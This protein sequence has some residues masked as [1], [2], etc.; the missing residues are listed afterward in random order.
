MISIPNIMKCFHESPIT[1][2]NSKTVAE[3]TFPLKYNQPI[4]K[5]NKTFVVYALLK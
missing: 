4:F 1:K 5:I 2:N 3:T